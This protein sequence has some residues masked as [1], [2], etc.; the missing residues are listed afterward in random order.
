MDLALPLLFIRLVVGLSLAA[1]GAQK[2]F[3]WFGGYGLA[4]TG[5]FF[6]SIGFRPG[7]LFALAAG[8]SELVGGLLIAA[9][10]FGPV[11]AALVIATMVV[12]IVTVHLRNGFF[13]TGNGIE[14]PL[15]YLLVAAIYAFAGYG[16]LGLDA[17][18]GIVGV[19]TPALVW[20]FVVLGIVGGVLMLAVRRT[21][22]RVASAAPASEGLDP[23]V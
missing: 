3:G 16:A 1:H 21:S 19:W 5:G 4:G 14:L 12:A 10:L 17:A 22:A 9:G 2:L 15:L 8:L 13:A 18:F 11:G 6:E 7:R 20:G 23:A